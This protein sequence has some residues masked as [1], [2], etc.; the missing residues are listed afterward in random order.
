MSQ[1]YGGI[2][3]LKK[4]CMAIFLAVLIPVLHFSRVQ[5]A[6]NQK[7]KVGVVLAGC[8]IMDGT[9]IY[10]AAFTI[11]SLE[12]ANAEI[13]FMAPN[14]PQTSVV[15]HF[16]NKDKTTGKRNVLA[17]SARIARGNIRDLKD[18]KESDIDALIIPGG[19]GTITTLSNLMSQGHHGSVN[20]DLEKLLK[21]MYNAKK[22]IGSMCAASLIV[23]RTLGYRNIKITIGKNNESF[24]SIITTVGANHIDANSDE[25]V[26]DNDNK[27]VS[28]P[29]YMG[30]PSNAKMFIGI[31]KMVKEVLRMAK[32]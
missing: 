25:I 28:T 1:N 14:I 9:E 31:D 18:V 13:I 32:R 20:A 6:D 11:L 15:N 23:A 5:S 21:D 3:M 12:N 24:E 30:G 2:Q 17:E 8:G 19:I 27:I 16:N 22:P 26:I 7:I 10:E 4:I 29:A